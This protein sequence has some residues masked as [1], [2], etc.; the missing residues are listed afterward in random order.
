VRK[1]ILLALASAVITVFGCQT[2]SAQFPGGLKIP[3]VSK[4]KPSPTP[5]G[6]AQP[7]S[8]NETRPAAQ[9]TAG[10]TSVQPQTAA[11]PGGLAVVK[12]WVQVTPRTITSYKGDS[13]TW[14][15]TPVIKFDTTGPR[16]SGSS[17]YVKVSLPGGA[18]WVDVDC[19]WGG[20]SFECGGP[21]FPE[22]KGTTAT[23]LFPFAIHLRN[24]LQGTDQTLFSGRVKIEKAPANDNQT[25][26]ERAKMS[27][28]YTN[29]EWSLPIG[30]VFYDLNR[31]ELRTAFWIRG[32]DTHLEL[33]AFYRGQEIVYD[34]RGTESPAIGSCGTQRMEIAPST[35]PAESVNPKPNWHFVECSF[36]GLPLKETGNPSMHKVA[37]NAGEYEIKVLRKNK[38][39]RTFKFTVGPDGRLAGGIPL[40]YR[41][42]EEGSPNLPGVIVPVAILD[43]QDGPWDRNAWK[44]DAFYGNPPAGF[45]PAP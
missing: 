26:A 21:N 5:A 3:K 16:P 12:H 6:A 40:I 42:G 31:N 1:H 44:T 4:P 33:H 23:G 28:Y 45:A 15:W 18:P 7:A 38:L 19:E 14:S 25:P 17:Y 41:V 39:S 11:E 8:P 29:L 27:V 32:D 36:V 9:P 2:A 34:F 35:F 37:S 30:Y 22:E 24:P 43:D 20:K 13:K 10:G